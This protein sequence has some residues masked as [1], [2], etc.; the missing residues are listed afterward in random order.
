MIS[1]VVILQK[2]NPEMRFLKKIQ[3]HQKYMTNTLK[4]VLQNASG[5]RTRT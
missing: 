5:W 1:S 4:I 2:Q 3:I